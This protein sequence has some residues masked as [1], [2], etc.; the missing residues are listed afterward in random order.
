MTNKEAFYNLKGYLYDDLYE[1]QRCN[2]ELR[3]IEKAI[4]NLDDLLWLFKT[5][6][7]KIEIDRDRTYHFDTAF[8]L[9]DYEQKH[10]CLYST[11]NKEKIDVLKTIKKLINNQ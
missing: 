5:L 2:G 1:Y 11:D 9:M 7:L 3:V 8:I 10:L 6:N 4:N